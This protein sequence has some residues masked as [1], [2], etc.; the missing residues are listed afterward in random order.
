MHDSDLTNSP[1]SVMMIISGLFKAKAKQEKRIR[2]LLFSSKISITPTA[3]NN[4]NLLIEFYLDNKIL[5]KCSINAVNKRILQ[6]AF[7]EHLESESKSAQK[8]LNVLSERIESSGASE[9]AK[10]LLINILKYQLLKNV[11]I[12]AYDQR[13]S[14]F[15]DGSPKNIQDEATKLWNK[16]DPAN[17]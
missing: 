16:I 17:T 11:T 2:L 1:L 15:M 3:K 14:T 10:E 13:I 8:R 9:Q 5:S 12:R 6:K 7:E 4:G